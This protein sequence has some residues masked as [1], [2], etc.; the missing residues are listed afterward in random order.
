MTLLVSSLMLMAVVVTSVVLYQSYRQVERTSINHALNVARI[1]QRSIS[2]NMELLSLDLDSVA[3]R[4]RHTQL[5][6]MP[7]QQQLEFLL[8]EKVEAG[9]IVAQGIVNAEGTLVVG[10]PILEQIMPGSFSGRD[11]FDMARQDAATTLYISPPQSV[12][13][14]RRAQ[15]IVLSKRLV[16]ADGSFAGIVFM[17]LYLDYFR[18][19]FEAM[20]L[21]KHAVMSLYSVD[22]VAYMRVPYDDAFIGSVLE[23]APQLQKLLASTSPAEGSYFTRSLQDGVQ[24]LYSYV[25]VPKTRWVVFIGQTKQT[26]FREWMR[27]LYA[28]LFLLAVFSTASVYLM[29]LLREEFFRRSKLDQ[30]LEE[31]ARTDKLTTLLNRRALDEGLQEAWHKCQRNQAARF[32]VL[33]TDVDFFKL[34]NDTYG[35]KAGDY[36][37]VAVARCIRSAVS[38]HFDRAGRYGGEEFV[39]LLDEADAEGALH[40]A[41]TIIAALQAQK[42]PHERSPCGRLT[43]S[44]GVACLERGVHRSIEEVVKAADQALYQ[45]KRDGR[46]RVVLYQAP[47]EVVPAAW[48][49]S[50]AN[51]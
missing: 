6:S 40:V 33:F 44:I 10:S 8:G 36:A 43:I 49:L 32:A 1:A 27:M 18:Q 16:H 25:R 51:S 29:S 13:L 46:N 20:S 9:Y 12:R 28:V 45:A 7:V 23:N 41:R 5:H 21:E 15:V 19:L 38:R 22:G 2:R 11:F 30:Q 48:Q 37:L 35:H 34:Y 24:R 26:L 4:Y 50:S 31:Q 39:V 17:V 3:W 47:T 42:I 14:E